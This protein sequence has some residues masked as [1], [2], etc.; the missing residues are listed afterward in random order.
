M[1]SF[2]EH[3]NQ[4][5]LSGR[6]SAT[7]VKSLWAQRTQILSSDI[8]QL[9]LSRLEFADSAGVAFL[10]EL[11]AIQRTLNPNFKLVAPAAQLEKLIALYDLEKF[12]ESKGDA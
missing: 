11:L 5:N 12:F 2:N 9:N 8:Q 10:L 4:C 3:A 1:A 6:L 7:E